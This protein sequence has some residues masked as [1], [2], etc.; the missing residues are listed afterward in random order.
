MVPRFSYLARSAHSSLSLILFSFTVP[1]MQYGNWRTVLDRRRD[2][3]SVSSVWNIHATLRLRFEM[4][5]TLWTRSGE[6]SGVCL[7]S[8]SPCAVLQNIVLK[9]STWEILC[10]IHFYELKVYM[11]KT[12]G[13][14]RMRRDAIYMLFINAVK[15][16]ELVVIN[17]VE[18]AY[19][20]T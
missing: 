19:R 15:Q 13:R 4:L 2:F 12:I 7:S 1:L 5:M 8:V 14:R 3:P 18:A 16:A 20:K 11:E 17:T 10:E 6:T 9:P